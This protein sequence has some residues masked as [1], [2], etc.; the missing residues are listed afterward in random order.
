MEN[1]STKY[2]FKR[3]TI[4]P[5]EKD[6][7]L[8]AGEIISTDVGFVDGKPYVCFTDHYSDCTYTAFISRKGETAEELKK[9]LN[10]I[11]SQYGIQV[12]IIKSDGG[13]EYKGD[14]D[15]EC[16][17]RGIRHLITTAYTKEQLGRGERR[18]RT[19]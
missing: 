8:V 18:N 14:F 13:P 4:Y 2:A 7:L 10:F 5:N 15:R 6:Q 11:Q 12:K 19:L 16:V 3:M 9:Y 17:E 1:K